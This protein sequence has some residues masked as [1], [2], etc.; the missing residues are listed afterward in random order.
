MN[1]RTA[2]Y[3]VTSGDAAEMQRALRICMAGM[4]LPLSL[5]CPQ[6]GFGPWSR[7]FFLHQTAPHIQSVWRMA[8]EG[9]AAGIAAADASLRWPAASAAAGVKLLAQREGARHWPLSRRFSASVT[10]GEAQGHFATVMALQAV[11]FSIPLLPLLQCV[12][13]AEWHAARSEP[14]D[15]SLFF[16]ESAHILPELVT[17]LKPH[18]PELHLPAARAL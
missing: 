14:A 5:S 10:A 8:M 1:E 7:T 2:L 16:Q 11:E 9:D 13:Y 3:A 12:L 4:H 6:G 18:A 17:F 15:P